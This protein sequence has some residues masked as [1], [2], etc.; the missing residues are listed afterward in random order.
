[1]PQPAINPI[2]F[3]EWRDGR[4]SDLPMKRISLVDSHKQMFYCPLGH[5]RPGHLPRQGEDE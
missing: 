5:L 3:R 2:T 1:M 4:S